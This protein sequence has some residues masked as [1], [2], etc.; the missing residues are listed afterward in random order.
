MCLKINACFQHRA[1]IVLNMLTPT[2]EKTVWLCD[3]IVCLPD[4]TF[5]VPVFGV[6]IKNS[7]VSFLCPSI[8]ARCEELTTQWF[9]N[10]LK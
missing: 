9:G 2:A 10:R 1:G 3:L 6:F 5:H 4:A 7:H 8:S